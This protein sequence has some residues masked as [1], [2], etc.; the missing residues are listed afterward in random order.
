[1]LVP[2]YYTIS[3]FHHKPDGTYSSVIVQLEA[4]IIEVPALYI[5]S[6][7]AESQPTATTRGQTFAINEFDLGDTGFFNG[8]NILA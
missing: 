1:M 8:R 2:T 5:A 4:V 3:V 7:K 6:A